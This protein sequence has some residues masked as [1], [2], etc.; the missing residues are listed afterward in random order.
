MGKVKTLTKSQTLIWLVHTSMILPV[1]LLVLLATPPPL[2][3][4][5]L[6]RADIPD[7][8]IGLSVS[9]PV[10]GKWH[11]LQRMMKIPFNLRYLSRGI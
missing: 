2:R 7:V 8:L 4:L 6:F 3:D 5:C 1:A 11:F 9:F 10:W